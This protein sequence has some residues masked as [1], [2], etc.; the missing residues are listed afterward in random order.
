MV[1]SFFFQHASGC[2][3]ML[4][5][6]SG[7][8][9]HNQLTADLQQQLQ[10]QQLMMSL[11]QCYQQISLQQ[12]E[13]QNMQ[14]QIQAL[15][16]QPTDNPDDSGFSADLRARSMQSLF[17]PM[18]PRQSPNLLFPDPFSF[19]PMYQHMSPGNQRLLR[20]AVDSDQ[21]QPGDSMESAGRQRRTSRQ[22]RT[23]SYR[24]KKKSQSPP[25][26][27]NSQVRYYLFFSCTN[28]RDTARKNV[29]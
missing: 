8:G 13:M 17:S 18:L 2:L 26:L 21:G 10:Q 28:H 14:R 4:F 1:V 19:N 24:G 7:F 11:N 16:Y 23:D 5:I 20:R 25:Q 15:L 22:S 27:N 12:M 6:L 29:L 9:S 3:M